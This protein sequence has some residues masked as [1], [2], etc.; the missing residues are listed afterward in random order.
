MK[1]GKWVG[2]GFT[3]AATA[4]AERSKPKSIPEPSQFQPLSIPGN[5]PI[6]PQTS[7]NGY[8]A[9][10]PH[11]TPFMMPNPLNPITQGGAAQLITPTQIM[12]ECTMD[13]PD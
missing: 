12:T 6:T 11:S 5:E 10:N 2:V 1:S 3:S 4:G 7:A 13:K 9:S 8:V